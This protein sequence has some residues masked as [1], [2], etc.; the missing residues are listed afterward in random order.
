VIQQSSSCT[1][2]ILFSACTQLRFSAATAISKYYHCEQ[3]PATPL[4]PLLAV[5]TLQLLLLL[6]KLLCM[7]AAARAEMIS[8][9]A[10]MVAAKELIMFF[11]THPFSQLSNAFDKYYEPYKF[12]K[13]LLDMSI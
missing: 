1:V 3:L 12:R 11:E 10:D 4:L 9:L 5:L 7:Q 2:D 6:L 8:D 13:V